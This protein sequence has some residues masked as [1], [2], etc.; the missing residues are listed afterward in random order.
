MNAYEQRSHQVINYM[1]LH[2]ISLEQD[3]EKLSNQMDSLDPNCKDYTYLDIEY[4][5]TNGQI[6]ATAHLLSVV[7]DILGIE[8]EEK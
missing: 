2:L 4:N 7:A 8:L 1:K 5:W 3:Q 6:T